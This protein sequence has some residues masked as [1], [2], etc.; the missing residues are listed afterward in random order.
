MS[1]QLSTDMIFSSSKPRRRAS[2]IM[3]VAPTTKP[4]PAIRPWSDRRRG[5]SSKMG[6]GG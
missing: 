4:T 3:R 1:A 2:R 6:I 5:P